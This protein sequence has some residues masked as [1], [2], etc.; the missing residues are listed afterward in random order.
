MAQRVAKN[1]AACLIERLH[2][3]VNAGFWP[4][5]G[6]GWIQWL[7]VADYNRSLADSALDV[8]WM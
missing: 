5:I 7:L 1:A 2:L 8:I 6:A 3:A 4:R